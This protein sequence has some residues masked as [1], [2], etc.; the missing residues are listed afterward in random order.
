MAHAIAPVFQVNIRLNPFVLCKR[1]HLAN[2][3]KM[4]LGCFSK[5]VG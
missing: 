1:N 5:L 3:A 2:L 4:L